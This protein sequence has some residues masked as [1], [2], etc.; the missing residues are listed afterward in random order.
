MA[1]GDGIA[2]EETR[3]NPRYGGGGGGGGSRAR[4]GRGESPTRS[5]FRPTHR[6]GVSSGLSLGRGGLAGSIRAA[7]NGQIGNFATG[8][9]NSDL[10]NNAG[11]PFCHTRYPEDKDPVLSEALGIPGYL[12]APVEGDERYPETTFNSDYFVRGYAERRPKSLKTEHSSLLYLRFEEGDKLPEFLS[13]LDKDLDQWEQERSAQIV[14]RQDGLKLFLPRVGMIEKQNRGEWIKHLSDGSIKLR[15]LAKSEQG[16]PKYLIK[17]IQ[18]RFRLSEMLEALSSAR[19]PMVRATWLIKLNLLK[20]FVD[21]PN[22]W[23]SANRVVHGVSA[24]RPGI[25]STRGVGNMVMASVSSIKHED[26]YLAK[27]RAVW[28]A[29]LF[30]YIKDKVLEISELK[31]VRGGIPLGGSQFK[32]S[33]PHG[34]SAQPLQN[35]SALISNKYRRDIVIQKDKFVQYEYAVRLARWQF[36]HDLV[37]R[38]HFIANLI[39]MMS[40]MRNIPTMKK[41]LP[42]PLSLC[43][44]IVAQVLEYLEFMTEKQVRR[45]RKIVI[46]HLKI[47]LWSGSSPSDS[48]YYDPDFRPLWLLLEL[49]LKATNCVLLDKCDDASA[50]ENCSNLQ[51][52]APNLVLQPFARVSSSLSMPNSRSM[53]FA[54]SKSISPSGSQTSSTSS[55]RG[56]T[57]PPSR[58]AT[59]S[60]PQPMVNL[61]QSDTESG[62]QNNTIDED[63][64]AGKDGKD[65]KQD[66]GD[67]SA[68]LNEDMLFSR[69]GFPRMQTL[70]TNSSKASQRNGGAILLDFSRNSQQ[71]KAYRQRMVDMEDNPWMKFECVPNTKSLFKLTSHARRVKRAQSS[72]GVRKSTHSSS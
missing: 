72:A 48:V 20:N 59:P 43:S 65:V 53:P 33:R 27:V 4:V 16:M 39:T 10:E 49:A 41:R 38:E 63:P 35:K 24:V 70:F 15:E 40:R 57:P 9:M 32:R 50:G 23:M 12:L 17:Q 37:D 8:N 13:K 34:R 42:L 61:Q 54:R 47:L 18:N 60:S 56:G 6:G 19:T 3:M 1:L 7:S 11:F 28:T 67:G 68:E 2:I 44:C 58:S 51:A 5:G 45:F 21:S 36:N 69:D 66:I 62:G 46:K 29:H 22:E 25:G 71:L 31:D 64:E 26:V 52:T 30:E 14:H 55:S